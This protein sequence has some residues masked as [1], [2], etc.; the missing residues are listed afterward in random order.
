MSSAI[1]ALGVKKILTILIL[2]ST[3][4][5]VSAY[6][7]L[8][9]L[10]ADFLSYKD[11]INTQETAEGY[12]LDKEI[13]RREMAK[14]TLKLSEK[15]ISNNCEGKFEDLKTW[16]WWCK[17]AESWLSYWFFAKNSTFNPNNNIS[18][19]E[20]LKMLVKARGIKKEETEDWREWYV[21]AGVKAGLLEKTFS[22]YDT[23]ATRWWIFKIWQNAIQYSWNDEDIDIINKLLNP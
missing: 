6:S 15:N 13:T 5:N 8:E 19:I 18:K 17:Y 3:I 1:S 16:D 14:V 20:A 2:I 10:A 7:S 4:I 12:Q 11:V 23:K 22:D 21:K 9:K